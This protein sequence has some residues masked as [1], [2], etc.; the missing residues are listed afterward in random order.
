MRYLQSYKIFENYGYHY[1]YP[2]HRGEL[3]FDKVVRRIKGTSSLSTKS[4]LFNFIT[5]L[6]YKELKKFDSP[7]EI[8]DNIYWHGTGS[9]VSKGLQAGFNIVRKVSEGGGGYG[10]QYHSI[11]LSKS[12]NIASNFT[13]M[14]RSG[15]VYPVLL[16]KG[17][18]VEE[19]PDIQD[20]EEI[21]DILVD[22]WLRKVDVVK[23]GKW[24]DGY[25]E[26]E[27]V[28][29]NPKAILKFEGEGFTV[30]QKKRF[31]NPTIDVY[32]AIFNTIQNNPFPN[33][34]E[35]LKVQY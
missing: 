17:A 11:S 14:S 13:G 21:E 4:D 1:M 5:I 10:E 12:K 22:L 34:D 8:M 2:K 29:L 7:E 6:S 16:R 15:M 32:K 28:V 27:L 20:S 18:I 19:I 25:S 3:T 9:Y 23:I 24:D 31:E 35:E 30:F 26:Q 33:R